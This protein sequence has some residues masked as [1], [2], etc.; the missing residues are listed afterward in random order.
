MFSRANAARTFC[1]PPLRGP[2]VLTHASASLSPHRCIG[3]A[4]HSASSCSALAQSS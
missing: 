1:P 3:I 4:Y 2:R